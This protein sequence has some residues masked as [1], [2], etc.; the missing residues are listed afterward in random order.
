MKGSIYTLP[1]FNIADIAPEKL[2]SQ[3]ERI[4]FQPPFFRG[5]V[6]LRGVYSIHII[7]FIYI[8]VYVQYH[9]Y[10]SILQVKQS[11]YHPPIAIV[12]FLDEFFLRNP[13]KMILGFSR[14]ARLWREFW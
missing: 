7:S 10:P 2:P 8:H 9:H 3:Q 4:V 1:K 14:R 5:N 6:K 11:I 13:G 12:F